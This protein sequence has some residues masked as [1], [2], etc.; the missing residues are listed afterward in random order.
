MQRLVCLG[1][2]AAAALVLGACETTD[3]YALSACERDYL[4]NR[5]R[6]IAAGALLGGAVGAAIDDRND[7]RGGVIGAAIGGAIASQVTREND[8]CGYG[9]GGYGGY[10]RYASRDRPPN[11]RD[12]YGYYDQYGRWIPR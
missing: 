6:A 4:A 2:I 12:G 8:P 11:Y 3:R 9:F 10:D 7:L 1:G 5:D